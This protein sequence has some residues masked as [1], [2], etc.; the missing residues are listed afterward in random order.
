[1]GAQFRVTD[2]N[3][4]GDLNNN[5]E[6]KENEEHFRDFINSLKREVEN[7]VGIL[8]TGGIRFRM[9]FRQNRNT[10]KF[11]GVVNF[12]F[13]DDSHATHMF[14]KIDGKDFNNFMLRPEWIV[15]KWY[16]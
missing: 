4:I 15:K 5:D 13:D 3:F 11:N 2:V 14:K 10:Q 8:S 1:M 6:Y 12:N 7:E 16:F 9:N